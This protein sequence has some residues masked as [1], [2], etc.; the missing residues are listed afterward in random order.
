MCFVC[1][2]VHDLQHSFVVEEEEEHQQTRLSL[3]VACV[4]IHISTDMH[5]L[6]L[7]KYMPELDA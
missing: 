4:Y 1:S 2:H 7:S 3:P 5:T 6:L